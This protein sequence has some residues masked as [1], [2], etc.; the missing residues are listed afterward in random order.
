MSTPMMMMNC[1]TDE[2][3]AAFLDGRLQPEA[4]A[5]VVEH[6]AN[7]PDCYA[8]VSAG[9]DY[10]AIEQKELAPVVKGRFG[11]WWKWAAVAAVAASVIVVLALPITQDAI[12]FR[13]RRSGL[14]AAQN[15]AESGVGR[16]TPYGIR[17]ISST[18]LSGVSGDDRERSELTGNQ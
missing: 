3:L 11:S 8:L 12:K 1:P 9:W 10:Q 13:S 6:I 4:R 16:G 2:T 17:R 18:V 5:E 14:I 15:S 7:C